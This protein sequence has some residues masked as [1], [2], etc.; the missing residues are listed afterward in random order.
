MSLTVVPEGQQT[1]DAWCNLSSAASLK[2]LQCPR[3]HDIKVLLL[4]RQAGLMERVYS[5][6]YI[7]SF[8]SLKFP[9]NNVTNT[10]CLYHSKGGRN[11]WL[12]VTTEVP[13]EMLQSH[14]DCCPSLSLVLQLCEY[15]LQKTNWSH[16]V[17]YLATHQWHW[18]LSKCFYLQKCSRYYDQIW[19][20]ETRCRF[21]LQNPWNNLRD[22]SQT[23]AWVPPPK[24]LH[25]WKTK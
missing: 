1:K 8:W 22:C 17:Q 6:T 23:T 3:S 19:E 16:L 21:W 24:L 10:T 7:I 12:N 13:V 5:H 14:M 20:A 2:S 9:S 4:R 15:G 25:G 11:C 18:V